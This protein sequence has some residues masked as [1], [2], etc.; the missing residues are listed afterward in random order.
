[1]RLWTLLVLLAIVPSAWPQDYPYYISTAAGRNP[2]GDGGPAGEAFLEFPTGIRADTLGNLFF[3]ESGRL[4]LRQIWQGNIGT[5]LTGSVQDIAVDSVGSV[6]FTDGNVGV[7][8]I[9]KDAEDIEQIAGS[10]RGFG[11][12]GGPAAAARFNGPAGI[13]VDDTGNVF[14]ADTNNCRVR[15]IAPSGVVQTVAGN[16]AC[17]SGGNGGPATAASLSYPWSV[18]V[19]SAGN[20]YIGERL[21]IRKV[22]P[23]GV[24]TQIAGGGNN[25]AEGVA[26]SSAPVGLTPYLA[27]D[28]AGNVYFADS[29]QH[30]VRVISVTGS[31]RTIAGTGIAGFSGD[32][33]QGA[34]AQLD[35]VAGVAVDSGGIVYISDYFNQR[36]RRIGLDGIITTLS[37]KTHFGG[38]GGPAN[39]ALLHLPEHAIS[40]A[41]GNL[42]ISDTDN[43]RVRKVDR[44]GTITTIAGT[45]QCANRG[46]GGPATQASLCVPSAL[47]LDAAGNLYVAQ[48]ASHVVRRIAA[49][50]TISTVAGTGIAGNSGDG[51]SAA[52]A[53]LNW[54]LGLA[55]DAAGNLYV[56]SFLGNVVRKITPS[57]TIATVAGTGAAGFSG[58]GGLATSAQLSGPAH[59]AFD[60]AGNLLVSDRYN[61]RVRRIANGIIT[62]IAGIGAC[63]AAG[64]Q[65]TNTFIG[66][67]SGVTA[68]SAGN[69]FIS[70]IDTY[71][72]WKLSPGGAIAAIAGSSHVDLFDGVP[73]LFSSVLGP[74]GLS[75]DP[76]GDILLAD[77]MNGH[78]RKLAWNPPTGIE[79]ASGDNQ[80]GAAGTTLARP[81]IV[82]TTFRAG[83]AGAGTPVT[84]AVVSGSATIPG[85]IAR[86]DTS[87]LAGVA[88]TLGSEAGPVVITATLGGLPPVTFHLTATASTSGAAAPAIGAG[89]VVGAG[90]SLPAV[91]SV[92][93]GG[94]ATIYG[95]NFAPPGTFRQVLAGDL[96][97]GALPVNLG[98]ACVNFG[99]SPAFLTLVTPSQINVQVP[100]LAPE[101]SVK[102]EVVTDC[103]ADGETRSAPE[104]VAVRAA[105]PEFLYWTKNASGFNPVVAVNAI[106][107][108]YIGG[109]DLIPGV[110][111]TPA[112]PGDYLILY[113]ISFG[114]TTPDVAPGRGAA[115]LAPTS[116]NAEVML[117]GNPLPPA[118]IF[119]AGLS[120]GTPG[121]YQL[122]IQVPAGLAAGLYPVTLKLGNFT[123]A[124]GAYLSIGK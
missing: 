76:N 7:F 54:P 87:G 108:A 38:D 80:T 30:R 123:A 48:S 110:A 118:A 50:G 84:F 11:G 6:Y 70:G 107:G 106:T 13:A 120:P 96:V 75:M 78:I 15:R 115:G 61:G 37:G 64:G 86:V 45:G 82:R 122:N 33:G 25:L 19:D 77:V 23:A 101:T 124:T 57:G 47:A 5:L 3:V 44:N 100:A 18:A 114:P 14:I 46:D 58:D 95:A 59:L 12:D 28:R 55:F 29:G 31:I 20:L 65:G 43:N 93:P 56:S 89:G 88:V 109:S 71:R 10:T 97:N 42:F 73:G 8:R 24:I 53:R 102:V 60:P 74:A 79:A 69:V 39:L 49:N 51:G 21:D 117:G 2:I 113:G 16:G 121:L 116:E 99:G 40:D 26:A 68:D 103:G 94:L 36:V 63:C 92:S 81:L 4:R 119:Y 111:F 112:K 9:F 62:T 17:G 90:G 35:T 83:F 105:T 91:H 34:S 85:G 1:L 104:P 41:A 66:Q 52:A 27:V 98:G 72:I 67:P 32:G 22:T